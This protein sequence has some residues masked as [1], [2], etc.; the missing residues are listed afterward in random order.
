[1]ALVLTVI[2]LQIPRYLPPLQQRM[3]AAV[4]RK[5]RAAVRRKMKLLKL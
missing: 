4:R 5:R 3:R 1:M 2:L